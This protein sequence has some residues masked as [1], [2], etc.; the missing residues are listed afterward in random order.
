TVDK[1]ILCDE[2]LSYRVL[3]LSEN[4]FNSSVPSFRHKSI[5]GYSPTKMQRYQDLIDRYL[6]GEIRSFYAAAGEA[7]TLEDI[8]SAVPEM[9]VM[10]MLNGKYIIIGAD[11]PPIVNP[12]A[13]GN[14]WVVDNVTTAASADEEIALLGEVDLK[15]TAVVREDDADVLPERLDEVSDGGA[16]KG[17]VVMT[18]YSPNE[19]KYRY[20]L[21][22]ESLVVFSEIF[23]PSWKA[24]CNGDELRLFRADWV[25]R[26]AVLPAGEGEIVMRY[27]PEDYA[28]G[29]KLSRI[30]SILLLVLLASSIAMIVYRKRKNI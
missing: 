21:P 16:G 15:T 4:T 19:L 20:S 12:Y 27:V 13:F 23:H 9:P 11:Y 30:C 24:S 6:S 2:S 8:Q 1:D 7:K 28:Q 29:E 18:Y 25:L 5:G 14:A 17:E 3:D 26:A 22:H 10:S